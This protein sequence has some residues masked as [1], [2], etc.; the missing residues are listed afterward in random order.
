MK[1]HIP[2][3]ITSLNLFCGCVGIIAVLSGK[4]NMG[5]YMI[6]FAALFD[7]FD[8]FSARLLNVKSEIGKQL[9]SLADVV[10]FGVL[11]GII[12]FALMKQSISMPQISWLPDAMAYTALLIPVFSA[13]RLAKFNI[14]T[15]Q[16]TSFL[17]VP[18]P[19][20]AI[21][22]G[23]F[24]LILSFPSHTLLGNFLQAAVGNYYVLLILSL[25]MSALLVSEIHLFALKFSSIKFADNKPQFLLILL[26]IILF[27]SLF[28]T[29]IPLI[30]LG[31]LVLSLLFKK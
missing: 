17:G 5:A 28:V 24:P 10:S 25:I 16:T 12:V 11:P 20:N 7:F 1:K 3:F 2:N 29:S 18:T 23:S 14:D 22:W 30:I 4:L 9:D 27:A 31:Y 8:G 13:I 15:R 21:L 6:A 19:A 26:S